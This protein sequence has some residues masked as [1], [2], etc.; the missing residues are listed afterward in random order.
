MTNLNSY[1]I[2]NIESKE[3]TAK[4]LKGKKNMTKKEIIEAMKD[5]NDDDEIYTVVKH[6]DK[7]GWYMTYTRDFDKITN[8]V[9]YGSG[10]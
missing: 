4:E 7:D 6:I 3:R 9:N 10:C 8:D 5:Y 1:D 2:I